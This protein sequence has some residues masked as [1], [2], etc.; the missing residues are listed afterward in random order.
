[1]VLDRSRQKHNCLLCCYSSLRQTRCS[2][3]LYIAEC[4]SVQNINSGGQHGPLTSPAVPWIGPGRLMG[5]FR[6]F[7]RAIPAANQ[8]YQPTLLV[9]V[10]SVLLQVTAALK[11][12]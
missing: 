6:V 4:G 8:G 5:C 1:M 3:N 7:L 11:A 2:P 12:P 10:F 9:D